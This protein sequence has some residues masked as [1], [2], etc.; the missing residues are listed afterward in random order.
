MCKSQSISF[1]ILAEAN[2]LLTCW[3]QKR[4]TIFKSNKDTFAFDIVKKQKYHKM[5]ID[6][7]V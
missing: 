7:P 1:E 4:S 5:T 2:L 3:K 6:K